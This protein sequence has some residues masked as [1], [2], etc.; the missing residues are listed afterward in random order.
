MS[1][2][3]KEKRKASDLS[4]L[5]ADPNVDVDMLESIANKTVQDALD[6]A[7]G[8]RSINLAAGAL[9]GALAQNRPEEQE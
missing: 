5:L 1:A 6:I 2:V 9:T 7:K 8:K 3:P 4:D